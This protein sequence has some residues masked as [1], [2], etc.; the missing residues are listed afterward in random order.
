MRARYT[1]PAADEL[2]E[3]LSY[4]REHAPGVVGQFA[5]AIDE[6]VTELLHNPYSAQE[7][8][9][10]GIRRKYVRRFKYS[11]FY[12]VEQDEVVIL[13]IRHAARQ[14]PIEFGGDTD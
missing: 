4:L 11:I 13:H 12:S 10:R 7:T 3:S 9:M 2:E 8:E 5:D 1:D 6:A 14:W